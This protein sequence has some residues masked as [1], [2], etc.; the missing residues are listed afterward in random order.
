ME[1][2]KGINMS[3]KMDITITKAVT[4]NTGNFGNVRPEVTLTIKDVDVE[5][6]EQ[7]TKELN[8]FATALFHLNTL[9]LLGEVKKADG[10]GIREYIRSLIEKTEEFEKTIEKYQEDRKWRV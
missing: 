7:E 4:I 10:E 8:D 6:V 1:R 2:K 5:N 3:K 9:S